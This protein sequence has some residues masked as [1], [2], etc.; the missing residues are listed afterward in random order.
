MN[1]VHV[2]ILCSNDGKMIYAQPGMFT[3]IRKP[4]KRH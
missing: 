3:I 1:K 4:R 2:V